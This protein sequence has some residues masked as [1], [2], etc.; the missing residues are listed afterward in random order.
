[1]DEIVNFISNNLNEFVE[2]LK[3]TNNTLRKT[4]QWAKDIKEF[5]SYF[6]SFLYELKPDYKTSR[7]ISFIYNYKNKKF[8][9]LNID[10]KEFSNLEK[11]LIYF[12]NKLKTI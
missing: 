8:K 3:L 11:A 2:E 1:M 6:W 9:F 4:D 5:D 7:Q 10:K 12:K